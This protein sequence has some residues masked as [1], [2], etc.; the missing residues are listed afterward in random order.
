MRLW[1]SPTPTTTEAKVKIALDFT[2][3]KALLL[4]LFLRNFNI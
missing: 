4:L 1:Y 3:F 2:A